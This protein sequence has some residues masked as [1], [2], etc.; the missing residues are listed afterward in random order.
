MSLTRIFRRTSFEENTNNE[1][2]NLEHCY[3]IAVERFYSVFW[4]TTDIGNY[5]GLVMD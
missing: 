5:I 2:L 3:I 1:I 4:V